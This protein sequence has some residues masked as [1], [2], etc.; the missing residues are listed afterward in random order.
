MLRGRKSFSLQGMTIKTKLSEEDVM[1]RD[2]ETRVKI[3]VNQM[4]ETRIFTGSYIGRFYVDSLK[5]YR[6]V[7]QIYDEEND[8]IRDLEVVR[9]RV[10]NFYQGRV[11]AAITGLE[12]IGPPSGHCL[13]VNL[14]NVPFGNY[15][16]SIANTLWNGREV[17]IPVKIIRTFEPAVNV[18]SST[19]KKIDNVTRWTEVKNDML[20][21]LL[22][23]ITWSNLKESF[24]FMFL[25]LMTIVTALIYGIQ[26]LGDYSIRFFR[27]F[28]NL[29][30]VSTPIFLALIE[31]I[32]K[33][34]GGFYILIAMLWRGHGQGPP[35]QMSLMAPPR[36]IKPAPYQ[37]R[38]HQYM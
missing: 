23:T 19:H 33:I 30:K 14:E 28:N 9:T 24:K 17:V 5:D 34:I 37:R 12:Y 11:W 36:A 22:E 18:K 6:D 27:E 8:F 7:I 31:M 32:S 20:N 13:W 1:S 21:R 16:F 38:S 2:E 4:L 25:L 3:F 35:P 29:I 10:E 26:Y 15:W